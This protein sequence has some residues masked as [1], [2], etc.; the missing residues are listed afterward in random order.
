MMTD[1]ERGHLIVTRLDNPPRLRIDHADPKITIAA[2]VLEQIHAG[3]VDPF[4]SFDGEVLRIVGDNRTV[5]YRITGYEHL[6]DIYDAEW[7]D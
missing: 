7:P 5:V 1:A 4:T 6:R 2:E 3:Q